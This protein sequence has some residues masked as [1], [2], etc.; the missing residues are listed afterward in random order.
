M[1][2]IHNHHHSLTTSGLTTSQVAASKT[3]GA[4]EDA[5]GDPGSG[6]RPEVV[7]IGGCWM[8]DI[9]GWEMG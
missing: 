5:V 7:S 1:M 4:V 3:T 6:R 9:R 8:V 2:K